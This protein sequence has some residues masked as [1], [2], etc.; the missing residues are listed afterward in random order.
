MASSDLYVTFGADTG[1]LEAAMAVAKAEV[2]DLTREINKLGREMQSTGAAGNSALATH[3]RAVGVELAEAKERAKGFKESLKPEGGEGE[4]GFLAGLKEHL[5]G[6]LA[7]LNSVR[8]NLSE[9]AELVAA[10]FVVETIADWISETTEAAEKFERM[11]AKLGIGVEQV[12]SLSAVAKL[13][14]SDV[15]Q[16]ASQ[17]E[18]LQLVARQD[19]REGQSRPPPR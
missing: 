4:G 18:R 8:E 15:D 3:L 10:A 12:Q 1:G 17:L 7:P 11:A 14:G 2:T 19:W 9:I 16:M 5:E 6:A 13:T